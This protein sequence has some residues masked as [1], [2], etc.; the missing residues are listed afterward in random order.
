VGSGKEKRVSKD[1]NARGDRSNRVVLVVDDDTGTRRVL[2]ELVRRGIPDVR[3][4]SARSYKE[5]IKKAIQE[6]PAVMVVDMHLGRGPDGLCFLRDLSEKVGW[7]PSVA[8]SAYAAEYGFNAGRFGVEVF[9]NKPILGDRKKQ[10]VLEVERLLSQRS[11]VVDA[12][13][14]TGPHRRAKQPP[15]DTGNRP[16]N[17]HSYQEV[18]LGTGGRMK[19]DVVIVAALQLELDA[20]LDQMR[21]VGDVSESTVESRTYHVVENSNGLRVAAVRAAGMG[22]M[23]AACLTRDIVSDLAPDSIIL[24]GIAGGLGNDVEL[25]DVV[26]SDQVV[27]YE[28]GKTSPKGFSPRWSA[29]KPDPV[30]L[31]LAQNLTDG[32]WRNQ[33]PAARPDRKGRGRSSAHVGVVLS[34]NKVIADEKTAGALSS[35]WSRS[36]AV[37]MEAAGIAAALYTVSSD[38]GFLMVKGICDKADSS[39]NDVWQPYAAAASAAFVATMIQS[40]SKK[41]ETIK[42]GTDSEQAVTESRDQAIGSRA[43]RLALAAAFDLGELKVLVFDL[44]IEWEDLAGSTKKEKVIEILRFAKRHGR[45]DDLI[46]LVKAER[47]GLLESHV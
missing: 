13:S 35:V 45:I 23:N 14:S 37:E 16:P 3:V 24:A 29:Y 12:Q 46:D 39:K 21:L 6:T 18:A 40:I 8:V 47:P 9:L 30:L 43:L 19:A 15:P 38:I 28:I 4:L 11:S 2:A 7:T 44:E 42:L 26:I 22:Q 32:P 41:P 1:S 20:M 31:N 34:G 36:T 33:I 17:D 10:L 25:G 27:D 5:G